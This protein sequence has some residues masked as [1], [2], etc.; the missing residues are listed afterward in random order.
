MVMYKDEALNS[1]TDPR[2]LR[3]SVAYSNPPLSFPLQ[4]PHDL[5]HFLM[6]V[7]SSQEVS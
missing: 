3:T 4:Y 7:V 1:Y 6:Q 5:G 2:R